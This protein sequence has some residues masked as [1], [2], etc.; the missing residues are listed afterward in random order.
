M[1][2]VRVQICDKLRTRLKFSRSTFSRSVKLPIGISKLSFAD[3]IFVDPGVKIN[4]DYYSVMLLS[5]QLLPVMRDVSGDFFIFQ[6]DSASPAHRA[7]DTVRFLSSQHPLSFFQ[8]CGRRI[9]LAPTLIRSITRYWVTSS[10]KC[11]SRSC[12]ALTN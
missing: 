10:N 1:W 7:R 6:Q 9:A 8:I 11:I 4:G 12:T 3:L 5:Q 2:E